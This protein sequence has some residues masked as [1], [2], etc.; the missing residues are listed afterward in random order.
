MKLFRLLVISVAFTGCHKG[1]EKDVFESYV[2]KELKEIKIG[3]QT[4]AD[5]DLRVLRYRNGD[6]IM[7][8]QTDEDWILAKEN[9]IGAWCFYEVLHLGRTDSI[10]GHYG[11][12]YNWYAI[13]DPRGLAPVGWHVPNKSEWDKL[14]IELGDSA[15]HKLK[16]DN[17]WRAEVDMEGN[18]CSVGNG[19]NE[20]RFSALPTGSRSTTGYWSG[21]GGIGIWYTTTKHRMFKH[22]SDVKPAIFQM[23]CSDYNVWSGGTSEPGNGYSV[24]CIRD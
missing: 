23:L 10:N 18:G 9:E 5:S 14:L 6:E 13:D 11:L 1:S 4:W 20:T 7:H 24:R 12:L 22:E 21:R 2:P 8:A 15:A 16:S 19:T 17:K 3:T